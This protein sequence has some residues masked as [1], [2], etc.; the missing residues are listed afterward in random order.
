M[1]RIPFVSVVTLIAFLASGTVPAFAQ[2]NAAA[3]AGRA[4]LR[5]SID[6]EAA[7]AA[8]QTPPTG[9]QKT[10]VRRAM[11]QG[12]G[13]G[14]GGMMVMTVIGTV[15]GLAATYFVVKEMRKQTEELT[16]QQQ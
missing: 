16:S 14:G 15:A 9:R 11:T 6:R 4:T 5:A 8:T 2:H 10:T 1:R 12:G 3:Q 7:K 13:G